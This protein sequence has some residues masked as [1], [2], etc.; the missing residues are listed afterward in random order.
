[1]WVRPYYDVQQKKFATLA[2]KKGTFGYAKELMLTAFVNMFSF[3]QATP[4]HLNLFCN[5]EDIRWHQDKGTCVIDVP[6]ILSSDV[7]EMPQPS[8]PAPS[9]LLAHGKAQCTT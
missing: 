4:R 1:M 7:E 9:R 2:G 3:T 5:R 8:T 6:P